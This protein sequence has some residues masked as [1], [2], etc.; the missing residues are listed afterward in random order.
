MFTDFLIDP[1][2]NLP[3]VLKEHQIETIK[4]I[5]EMED[6]PVTP[7][8]RGGIIAQK[9]GLGKTLAALTLCMSTDTL[10][11]IICSKTLINEWKLQIDKFLGNKCSYLVVHKDYISQKE[12]DN[13]SFQIFKK[14][15][16]IL[17]TYD[18][19][20]NISK[21]YNIYDDQLIKT[22]T[23]KIQ[24]IHNSY[25]PDYEDQIKTRGLKSVFTTV[26]D[27]I[28]LDE[29]H[30]ISN[31]TSVTFYSIM[32]LYGKRKLC[33][34][35]SPIK[36]YHTDIYS[37]LRFIGYD[38]ILTRVERNFNIDVYRD[39][40][41]DVFLNIKDYKE[42]K[43]IPPK[44]NFKEIFITLS[45]EEEEIYELYEQKISS[46][47]SRF[48]DKLESF[49]TIIIYFIRLRQICIA[50]HI[51]LNSKNNLLETFNQTQKDWISNRK[52]TS[53]IYSSK[54]KELV[55]I[56]KNIPKKEK[57]LIFTSFKKVINIASE[58]LMLNGF[59]NLLFI[60]GDI[61]GENR[62]NIIEEFKKS[63]NK[64]ILFITYKV[65]SEGLNLIEA[66]HIIL[67][68]GWWNSVSEDQA[69]AR[70]ARMGQEKT[71][72]VYKLIV[73]SSKDKKN[74]EENMLDLCKKKTEMTEEYISGSS[75]SSIN[76]SLLEEILKI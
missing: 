61:T 69:V 51:I 66:N 56:V 40:G 63:L 67:I 31:F 37:Q 60:N 6:N 13:L 73:K 50:P 17:T 49:S 2:T 65:G 11:L 54:M 45:K 70:S 32:S 7:Q 76:F 38:D 35:G 47:F 43:L 41:L 27:R 8:I 57:I 26:W 62:S 39:R 14:Y 36:N 64:N 29:S 59:N 23:G 1:S 18:N 55:N 9:M 58:A 25:E 53:G 3:F 71:V 33:L 48:K 10:N 24:G 75:S 20:M 28:I 16:I 5:K 44:I 72:N 30:R 21:K 15:K 52:G 4:W 74:I 46:T 19:I 34:S 42:A 22:R 68:E 12:E